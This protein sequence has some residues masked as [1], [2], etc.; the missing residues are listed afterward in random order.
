MI[1]GIGTDIIEVK[2]VEKLYAKFPTRFPMRLLTQQELLAFSDKNAQTKIY[3][4]A[5]KFA[6][7]EAIAKSLGTGIAQGIS[8]QHIEIHNDSLGKPCVTL[9]AAALALAQKN[10]INTIH[11]SLS[12]ERNLIA[13]FAVAECYVHL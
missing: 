4:L 6:A 10:H 8:F 13:A 1:Y 3:F 12:D 2:R 11:L 7:K 5:K 9:S